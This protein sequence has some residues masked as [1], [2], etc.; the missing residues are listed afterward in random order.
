MEEGPEIRAKMGVISSAGYEVTFNKLVSEDEC[1]RHGVV[2]SLA[3]GQSAG[4]VM[5]NVGIR[6]VHG[7]V[8]LYDSLMI[9]S[10]FICF[11]GGIDQF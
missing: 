10:L 7:C 9:S 11:C 1:V 2:R 3:F 6:F 5:V 8:D 4:F